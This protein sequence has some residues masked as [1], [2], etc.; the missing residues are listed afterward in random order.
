MPP[1]L[2]ALE[3]RSTTVKELTRQSSSAN[4]CQA[5]VPDFL[6]DKDVAGIHLEAI[7]GI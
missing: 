3:A 6:E 5:S 2:T 7:R 1:K 4:M